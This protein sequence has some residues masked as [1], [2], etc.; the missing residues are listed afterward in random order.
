MPR[1]CPSMRRSR[2]S[3]W[4]LVAVYPRVCVVP[5]AMIAGAYHYPVGVSTEDAAGVLVRRPLRRSVGQHLT[6]AERDREVQAALGLIDRRAEEVAQLS[7][8]VADR[9]D[10]DV[11]RFGGRTY[12]A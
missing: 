2:A 9:L 10:V 1:T 5:D 3:N 7:E 11:E 6:G 4:S 8:A 12:L